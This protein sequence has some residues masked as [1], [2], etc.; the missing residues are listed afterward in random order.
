MFTKPK[1]LLMRNAILILAILVNGCAYYHPAQK[2]VKPDDKTV[3]RYDFQ[4]D[5]KSLRISGKSL[6]IGITSVLSNGKIIQT[7][8]L[9]GGKDAWSKYKVVVDGGKFSGGKITISKSYAYKKL[10]SMEV[11]VYTRTHFLGKRNVW[12]FTQKIPFNYETGIHI[13]TSGTYAK[14]PGNHIKFGIRKDFDNG[15][16]TIIWPSKEKKETFKLISLS[17]IEKANINPSSIETPVKG[18]MIFPEGGSFSQNEFVIDNNPFNIKNHTVKLIALLSKYPAI[19]DTLKIVLDYIDHYTFDALSS[20]ASFGYDGD[21]EHDLNVFTDVHLDTIINARLMHVK[22]TDLKNNQ[23]YHYLINTKGGSIKIISRGRDGSDGSSVM[24]GSN[25]S[26]GASGSWSTETV[27]VNDSTTT[28]V[29]VQGPGGNG[30]DGGDGSNGGDGED[31]GDGGNININ[32]TSHAQPYLQMINAISTGGRGGS[33]G[34]GGQGGRGGSGGS[35]N[36]SG[37]SGNNG[38]NGFSGSDGRN[39]REGK[40]DIKPVE[41]E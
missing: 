7:K 41:G 31:G 14:A 1:N 29:S 37:N 28:T 17:D 40:I 25:G 24:D 13:I 33:G 5:Q 32:Y 30:Q 39:G 12:L 38:H 8:G 27:Q 36:P 11:N 15:M 18:F 34:R 21:R 26:D 2:G 3:D 16:N 10:D 22:I 35:G 6:P 4:Y 20:S 23:I 19:K 9:L